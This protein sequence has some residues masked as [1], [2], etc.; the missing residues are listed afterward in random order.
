MLASRWWILVAGALT[1]CTTTRTLASFGGLEGGG[2]RTGFAL[3]TTTPFRSRVDANST[4]YLQSKDGAWSSPVKARDAYADA[5]GIWI[6]K[7]SVLMHDVLD[8][9]ELDGV[10]PITGTL[11]AATQPAGGELVHAPGTDHYV[12]QGGHKAVGAWLGDVATRIRGSE[13]DALHAPL[14][15]IV[16]SNDQG[17]RRVVINA[18]LDEFDGIDASSKFGWAWKDIGA[19]EVENPSAGKT[20][21]ATVGI[22]ALTAALLPVAL[23][24]GALGG[25]STGNFHFG[26]P[27]HPSGG[28]AHP[29]LEIAAQV[30]DAGTRP[31]TP[32]ATSDQFDATLAFAPVASTSRMFTTAARVHGIIRGTLALDSSVAYA[33]DHLGAGLIAKVRLGEMFELGA[34]A[35][36]VTTHDAMGWR[37]STTPVIA[38]NWHLPLDAEYRF[39]IPVGFEVSWGGQVAHDVRFPIGL[40]YTTHDGRY[41]GT[42]YPATPQHVR[43]DSEKN[44]RW[45]LATSLELGVSF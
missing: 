27:R 45:S 10:N 5:N 38:A 21:G 33:G 40:R 37:A 13:S 17:Y 18:A 24:A 28:G 16:G 22:A 31:S 3:K 6:A 35:R 44:G 4:F 9:I 20:F 26:H 8:F 29:G 34:G 32:H 25:G 15:R 30:I 12:L 11:L 36:E 19:V 41:F 23:A 39:A 2:H 7:E 42:L 43:V 1:A 14:F